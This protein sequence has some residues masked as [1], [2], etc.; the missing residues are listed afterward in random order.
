MQ[1]G[2]TS[3]LLASL[4]AALVL[5]T[6]VSS[7]AIP[8]NTRNVTLKYPENPTISVTNTSSPNQELICWASSN[9]P[10]YAACK[11]LWD[12]V[13]KVAW[14]SDTLTFGKTQPMAPGPGGTFHTP[15]AWFNGGCEFV[16]R[17]NPYILPQE[18]DK[19]SLEDIEQEVEELLDGCVKDQGKSGALEVGPREKMIAEFLGPRSGLVGD[20]QLQLE[21]VVASTA[22]EA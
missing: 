4:F 18:D 8:A 5:A 2:A 21:P 1:Q 9:N 12:G 15:N 13:K 20:G 7:T 16:I 22:E 19:F 17:N 3:S 14:Y 6:V 11:S 10:S